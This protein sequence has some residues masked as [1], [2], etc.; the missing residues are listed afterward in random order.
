MLPLPISVWNSLPGYENKVTV[1]IFKGTFLLASWEHEFQEFPIH[2]EFAFLGQ[3][4]C[5]LAHKLP[6]C[7][8]RHQPCSFLL[9]LGS[10][11]CRVSQL[12][13]SCKCWV[14][15]R[16]SHIHLKMIFSEM[17]GNL[18]MI[19]FPKCG[20]HSAHSALFQAAQNQVC[21]MPSGQSQ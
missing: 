7:C 13:P 6:W 2:K 19:L 1:R 4:D 15:P 11:G 18:C 3:S 20:L 12:D 10:Q 21:F 17:P 16:V 8:S 14:W 5:T 9:C